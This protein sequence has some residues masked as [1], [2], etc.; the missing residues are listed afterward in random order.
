MLPSK[1]Q[2]VTDFL[3]DI[4]S[5]SGEFYAIF[6]AARNIFL[7]TCP[8]LTETI[9]Y[10]GIV[11]LKD[12]DLVGGIFVY[13]AHLSIEF[14]RG[15]ELADPDSILEGK[16]QFRRHIKLRQIAD[17]GEKRLR[18]FVGALFS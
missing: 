7:E 18:Q 6:L 1:D 14:G 8:E 2:R 12:N 4:Q 17:V 9:K 13:K 5:L 10:G 3:K 15:A 16:G 11:F